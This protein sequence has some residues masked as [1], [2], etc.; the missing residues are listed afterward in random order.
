MVYLG[1]SVPNPQSVGEGPAG[2]S[3]LLRRAS[4]WCV[5]T[6]ARSYPWREMHLPISDV[7]RKSG[8]RVF[9]VMF[10]CAYGLKSDVFSWDKPRKSDVFLLFSTTPQ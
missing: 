7:C 6:R 10:F 1:A 4:W 3:A 9:R 2:L 5:S 8:F